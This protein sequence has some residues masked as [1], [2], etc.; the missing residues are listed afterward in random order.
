MPTPARPAKE[1]AESFL[2]TPGT[3]ASATLVTEASHPRSTELS[4]I[5]RQDTAAGLAVL[6]DV[7]RDVVET[8]D[9]WSRTG[10]PAQ[11]RDDLVATLEGGGRVFF[12]GCGAT[13]RLSI[14]LDAIWR[15]FW[16]DRRERGLV[17]PAARRLGG[18]GRAA[19]WPAATSRS[20]SRSRASRTS[21]RSAAGRSPT[22]ASPTG[23][24]VFAIT[25]GGETSFVIGTAWQGARGRR[26]RLLRLQ[27]SRR[28]PA[29]ARPAQPRG[30][31]RAADREARPDDRA[32]GH[33]RLDADA[34]DEHRA[35]GD[36]HRAGDGLR[37]L[38]GSRGAPSRP[39]PVGRRARGD[40]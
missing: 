1:R 20:S 31:R 26:A 29:G 4:Q 39:R 14:Q 15:A 21:R 24:V 34:G 17:E 7:D 10:Q 23:D 2:E 36:A 28:R 9:R 18:P 40:A 5:A 11:L 37:E 13:G 16:Q 6:F 12:T 3:S 35:A 30:H 25:E 33:H 38:L 19:S 8:Y 27:Q 22:S 32:D